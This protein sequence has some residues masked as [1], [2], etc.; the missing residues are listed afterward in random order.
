[1]L[2]L[3]VMVSASVFAQG[4]VTEER[5]WE[6][7]NWFD[8]GVLTS[9]HPTAYPDA[10]T[11]ANTRP[12]IWGAAAR[13]A[14]EEAARSDSKNDEDTVRGT[15]PTES[16]CTQIKGWFDAGTLTSQHSSAL[17]EASQCSTTYT[18]LWNAT[19]DSSES[20]ASN[21][22]D[23]TSGFSGTV[24]EELCREVKE[25]FDRGVLTSQ[26]DE[27]QDAADLCVRQFS[28]IWEG[29]QEIPEAAL[30]DEVIENY[31]GYEN[32]FPD[33]D[34]TD[35][36][37]KAA[38]E[39]WRRN[40]IT[41]YQDGEFKGG[42]N[43]TR[44]EAAKFF[45]QAANEEVDT[46]LKNAG[47][48]TDVFEDQW[49]IPYI[50]TAAKAGVITGYPDGSYKPGNPV[51]TAEFLVMMAKLFG[52][53]TGLPH[54]YADVP[55]D[56]W[57]AQYAGIAVEYALFPDR[58]ANLEPGRKLTRQEVAIALYQYLKNR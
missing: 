44:A 9:Q 42:R 28:E 45:L 17:T 47:R 34:L 51:G 10:E 50:M 30:E 46:S 4:S 49:Y 15:A 40:I 24:D 57:Y 5:C 55:A 43:V 19:D 27:Y 6:V 39:L 35:L 8:S 38:A 31:T 26:H 48:F 23:D 58:S 29:K 36:V 12:D 21:D 33:T 18:D 2:S 16:R 20:A 22:D 52:L 53:E 54:S 13:A 3:I 25:W 37:G 1:M 11:C 32:P 14:A 7:K 41:G 56:Q